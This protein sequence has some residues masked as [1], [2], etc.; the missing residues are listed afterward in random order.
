MGFSAHIQD[1]SCSQWQCFLLVFPT[2]LTARLI[3][4]GWW[5]ALGSHKQPGKGG[6][7]IPKHKYKTEERMNQKCIAKINV[8]QKNCNVLRMKWDCPCLHCCSISLGSKPALALGS[9]SEYPQLPLCLSTSPF[10][11]LPNNIKPGKFILT[12]VFS[13]VIPRL[14]SQ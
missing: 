6:E 13:G 8:L 12:Q 4:G 7:N 5:R 14:L 11:F 3:P 9:W 2:I 10:K 1:L